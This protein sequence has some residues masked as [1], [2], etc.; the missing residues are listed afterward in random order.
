MTD[1]KDIEELFTRLG[2]I[3]THN[4]SG[5]A[6]DAGGG[7]TIEVR[8]YAGPKQVGYDGFESIFLFDDDGAFVDWGMYE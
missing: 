6:D 7:S 5:H 2:I 1:K 3:Y 4:E 8:S